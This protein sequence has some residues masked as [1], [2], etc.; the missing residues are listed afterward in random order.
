[1]FTR[2]VVIIGLVHFG[3]QLLYLLY[4]LL[5]FLLVSICYGCS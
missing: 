3:G 1:L 5:L 2:L 4:I